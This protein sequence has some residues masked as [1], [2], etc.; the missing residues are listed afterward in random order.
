MLCQALRVKV[1][2]LT[3]LRL[4]I[5]SMK[6]SPKLSKTV[7]N[8][9]KTSI[10]LCR[11]NLWRCWINYKTLKL[12]HVSTSMRT[13]L[14]CFLLTFIWLLKREERKKERLFCKRKS[15]RDKR[16]E[17]PFQILLRICSRKSWRHSWQSASI[18]ITKCCLTPSMTLCCNLNH[19]ERMASHCHGLARTDGWSHPTSFQ[20]PKYS[21]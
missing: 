4:N 14:R 9:W 7:N 13:F 1:S 11:R 8:S 5:M 3:C 17:L 16:K 10:S 20:W 6:F 12:A 18:F 2:K 19:L 15:R 21:K